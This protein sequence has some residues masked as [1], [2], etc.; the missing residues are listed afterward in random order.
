M[1]PFR[2]KS[3]LQD[4]LMHC[5]TTLY[6][7]IKVGLLIMNCYTRL[8]QILIVLLQDANLNECKAQKSSHFAKIGNTN[9]ERLHRAE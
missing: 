1:K 6:L 4:I 8:L 5:F 2:V 3:H 7:G 9:Q